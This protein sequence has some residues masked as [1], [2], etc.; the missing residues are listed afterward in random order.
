MFDDGTKRQGREEGQAAH[1][2]DDAGE[3]AVQTLLLKPFDAG[4]LREMVE[5]WFAVNAS[6]EH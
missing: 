6:V 5:R 3:Q 2:Q 1:D 4:Q